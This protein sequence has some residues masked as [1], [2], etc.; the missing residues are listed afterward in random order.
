MACRVLSAGRGAQRRQRPVD[1]LID[2]HVP[3]LAA[4]RAPAEH[5]DAAGEVDLLPRQAEQLALAEPGVEVNG[6]DRQQQLVS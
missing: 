5:D 6:H 4:L 1:R 3:A 2:R